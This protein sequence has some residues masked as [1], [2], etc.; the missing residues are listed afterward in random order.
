LERRNFTRISSISQEKC[1]NREKNL[2]I[3][4]SPKISRF[5]RVFKAD[6]DESP[7]DKLRCLAANISKD[8]FF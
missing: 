8:L 3:Q 2:A 5:G 4:K 1:R 7:S 6:V